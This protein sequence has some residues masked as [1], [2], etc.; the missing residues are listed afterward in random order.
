M[1]PSYAAF[2]QS[3][4]S[5]PEESRL[6]HPGGLNA[7]LTDITC[8]NSLVL[9]PRLRV[10]DGY[11]REGLSKH[12]TDAMGEIDC[13]QKDAEG[14]PEVAPLF[15]ASACPSGRRSGKRGWMCSSL[16]LGSRPWHRV[17][18]NEADCGACPVQPGRGLARRSQ[19]S[20]WSC[21]Q[22]GGLTRRRGRGCG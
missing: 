7:V 16:G 12:E 20:R 17:L 6:T 21:P 5:A 11:R 10:E 22:K 19:S 1:K 15:S 13:T 3:R 2:M 9:R 14:R 4:F 8:E 18:A